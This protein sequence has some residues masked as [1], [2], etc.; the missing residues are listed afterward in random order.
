M[1][2]VTTQDICVVSKAL[3]SANLLQSDPGAVLLF[4]GRNAP[5]ISSSVIGPRSVSGSKRWMAEELRLSSGLGRSKGSRQ[6]SDVSSG[7]I[8]AARRSCSLGTL[9]TALPL[10]LVRVGGVVEYIRLSHYRHRMLEKL[11][12]ILKSCIGK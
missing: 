9:L 10:T 1:Q 2:A 11:Q 5:F 4:V 8:G 3:R 6:Y 7:W 12:E